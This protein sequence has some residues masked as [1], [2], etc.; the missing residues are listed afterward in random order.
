MT[1]F[2]TYVLNIAGIILLGVLVHIILPEGELNKFIQNIFALIVVFVIVSPISGILNSSFSLDNIIPTSNN[3]IDENYIFTVNSQTVS[4]LESILE[5]TLEECGFKNV[6]VTISANLMISPLKLEKVAID[7]SKLVMN[8]EVQH[9]NKYS[10]IKEI[11][12]QNIDI[13]EENIVFYG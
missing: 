6:F 10:K 13:K 8:R 1:A 5:Q 11:V 2:S 9:I 4:Y 7:L 12:M 3:V